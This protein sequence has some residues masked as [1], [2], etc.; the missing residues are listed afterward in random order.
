MVLAASSREAH[1]RHGTLWHA[2]DLDYLNHV[3]PFHFSFPAL[4]DAA[5][6]TEGV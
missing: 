3:C 1:S 4:T 6:V 5:V 2:R